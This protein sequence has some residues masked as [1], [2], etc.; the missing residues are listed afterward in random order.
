ME[1]GYTLAILGCGKLGCSIGKAIL[2]TKFAGYPGKIIVCT[3]NEESANKA[4]ENLNS[5]IVTHSFG[6]KNNVKAIH[7]SRIIILGFKPHQYK[8]VYD[9]IKGGL[10]GKQIVISLLAGTTLEELSIFSPFV[11]RAMCNIF[12]GKKETTIA[13]SFSKEAEEKYDYFIMKMFQKVC[14]PIKIP[15]SKM[16]AVSAFVGSGPAYYALIMEA[17]IDSGVKNGLSYELAL[18]F[19]S[20][21]IKNTA[22]LILEDKNTYALRLNVCTPGGMSIAGVSKLEE[23]GIRN[24]IIKCVDESISVSKILSGQKKK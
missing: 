9:E 2:K 7:E 17:F 15:E 5:N 14:I 23:Y 16:D 12:L 10:T 1:D 22:D 6:K 21:V 19:T 13:I 24:A 20:N 18:L 4:K 11:V 8:Q 3:T